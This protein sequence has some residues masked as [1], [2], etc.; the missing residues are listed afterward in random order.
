MKIAGIEIKSAE[1]LE[2]ETAYDRIVESVEKEQ[3]RVGSYAPHTTVKRSE[4]GRTVVGKRSGSSI[5]TP[6]AKE[7]KLLEKQMDFSA[8]AGQPAELQRIATERGIQWESALGQRA[9]PYWASDQRPDAHGDIVLQNWIFD[10]FEDN[11]PLANSHDWGG[12]PI[13]SVLAWQVVQRNTTKYMGPALQLLTLFALKEQ[14][15]T[16][17]TAFRLVRSG[18]L[19]GGSVGFSADKVIDIKDEAERAKL[20]LGRWGFVLDENHLLEFS[21]TL[22]GANSG[23]FAILSRAKSRGML[24]AR[25]MTVVRELERESIVESGDKDRWSDLDSKYVQMAKMLFPDTEWKRH[26]DVEEPMS[27]GAPDPLKSYVPGFGKAPPPPP[28]AGEDDPEADPN[29]DPVEDDPEADPEDDTSTEQTADIATVM[30]AVQDL[31][32]MVETGLMAIAVAVSDIRD[33]VEAMQANSKT[34]ENDPN[35]DP[36]EVDNEDDSASDST[37][38]SLLRRL[39]EVNNDIKALKN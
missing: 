39:E 18:F 33:A 17:D 5:I 37:M 22:L 28:K 20:G 34:P 10:E 23:A 6:S 3:T 36:T 13:G 4:E 11:H 12:F 9:I 38:A 30:A 16:A 1:L 25:D 2:G 26:D 27:L 35:A 14:F 32:T 15:E 7:I 31:S 29:A 24:E 21:P 19:V 8:V